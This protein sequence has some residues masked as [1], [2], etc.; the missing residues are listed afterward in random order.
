MTRIDLFFFRC[1]RCNR[2][3]MSYVE[4]KRLRNCHHEDEY[5]FDDENLGEIH[6]N[7]C[8]NPIKGIR[9]CMRC[10]KGIDLL[11]F[12]NDIQDNNKAVVV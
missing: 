4:G 10:R 8:L 12:T 6:N 11:G 3:F 7:S 2:D 1:K 5:C 9:E